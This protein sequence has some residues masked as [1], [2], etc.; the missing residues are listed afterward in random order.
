[1]IY[2]KLKKRFKG[3]IWTFCL[4]LAGPNSNILLGKYLNFKKYVNQTE[5]DIDQEKEIDYLIYKCIL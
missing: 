4:H 2:C 5:K 3:D 1:M